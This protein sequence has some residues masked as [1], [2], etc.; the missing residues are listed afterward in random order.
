[1]EQSLFFRFII[2][3][4][5]RFSPSCVGSAVGPGCDPNNE[6]AL[7]VGFVLLLCE[8]GSGRP[9]KR[10]L[11]PSRTMIAANVAV[12]EMA[13]YPEISQRQRWTLR[14]AIQVFKN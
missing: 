11:T 14:N 8:P 3:L 7:V 5:F 6:D 2:I 10:E 1:M 4:I 13:H 9:E 12:L